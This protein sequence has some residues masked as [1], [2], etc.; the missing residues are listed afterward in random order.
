MK[1]KVLCTA[2][3]LALASASFAQTQ[4]GSSIGAGMELARGG[5]A[6][7]NAMIP[8][9]KSAAQESALSQP[10]PPMSATEMP[11]NAAIEVIASVLWCHAS[12]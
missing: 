1:V 3:L 7:E 10:A 6:W 9:A 4:S 5:S 2:A 8:Q 12:V 11:I